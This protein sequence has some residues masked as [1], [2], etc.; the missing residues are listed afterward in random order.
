M[1]TRVR[2]RCAC[3][4]EEIQSNGVWHQVSAHTSIALGGKCTHEGTEC[5]GRMKAAARTADAELHDAAQAG[6]YRRRVAVGSVAHAQLAVTV[7]PKA[8]DGG[9]AE[10]RACVGNCHAR[11]WCA[12]CVCVCVCV[13]RGEPEQWQASIEC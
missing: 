7:R 11:G 13:Q 6:N 4:N 1:Y 10:Q 12:R 5:G 3:S 9:V 8:L 2:E